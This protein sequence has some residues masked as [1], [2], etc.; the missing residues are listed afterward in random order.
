[1][2]G[3]QN[4][5]SVFYVPQDD[6]WYNLSTAFFSGFYETRAP[7]TDALFKARLDQLDPTARQK[8]LAEALAETQKADSEVQ[9]AKAKA[10]ADD[11]NLAWKYYNTDE[12]AKSARYAAQVGAE[13][14]V[15]SEQIHSAT[16]ETLAGVLPTNE[17]PGAADVEAKMRALIDAGD[18]GSVEAAK[19]LGAQY[20]RGAASR[21]IPRPALAATQAHL[22]ELFDVP[23]MPENEK[24]QISDAF[25]QAT[26]I[27]DP[28]TPTPVTGGVSGPP[29]LGAH[30]APTSG[31]STSTRTSYGLRTSGAPAADL[32][33]SPR[34]APGQADAGGGPAPPDSGS[35]YGSQIL[36]EL[37][38]SAADAKPYGNFGEPLPGYTKPDKRERAF[39][40]RLTEEK[41]LAGTEAGKDLAADTGDIGIAAEGRG[42]PDRTFRGRLEA[43]REIAGESRKKPA[44]LGRSTEGDLD[45]RVAVEERTAEKVKEADKG[46]ATPG[47]AF[48][49]KMTP[50]PAAAPAKG[51]PDD[52][53]VADDP[54]KLWNGWSAPERA[55]ALEAVGLDPS[56]TEAGGEQWAK[57]VDEYNRKRR[58][59]LASI[60]GAAPTP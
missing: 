4:P 13:S 39:T 51:R 5:L 18:P 50:A 22:K 36:G 29:G 37:L 47:Q 19:E 6:G 17:R 46:S 11:A 58:A 40:E 54:M 33:I 42:Q 20:L 30:A 60:S 56:G 27:A 43:L 57:A 10:A 34:V 9:A 53:P 35:S 3:L 26:A 38:Q 45:R 55:A 49:A 1:M 14:R 44:D 2:P 24:S 8:A 41:R 31:L 59:S 28:A 7:W 12:Q 25:S 48:E 21:N 16:Q 23:N 52:Q 15:Q 32:G